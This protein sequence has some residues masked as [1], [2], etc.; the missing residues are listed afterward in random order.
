MYSSIQTLVLTWLVLY[1]VEN[2]RTRLRMNIKLVTLKLGMH[3][4]CLKNTTGIYLNLSGELKKSLI[5]AA[6]HYIFIESH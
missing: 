1:N 3:N 2:G 6:V 5:F 4:K